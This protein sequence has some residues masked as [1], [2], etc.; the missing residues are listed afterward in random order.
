MTDEELTKMIC[1]H[2]ILFSYSIDSNLELTLNFYIN[3]LG[4]DE[5]LALVKRNPGAFG[6][7]LEKRLKPR[8]EE[9]QRVGMVI[10]YMCLYH[11]IFCTNDKWDMKIKLILKRRLT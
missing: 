2:P 7:S 3:A 9:A 10:D 5:A 11:I 4:K 8:L 6:R 1:R